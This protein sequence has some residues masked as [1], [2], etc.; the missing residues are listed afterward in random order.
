MG[1]HINAYP[2]S[3]RNRYTLVQFDGDLIIKLY[4]KHSTLL[5][6][7]GNSS[8]EAWNYFASITLCLYECCITMSKCGIHDLENSWLVSKLNLKVLFTMWLCHF[9]DDNHDFDYMINNCFVQMTRWLYGLH[10]SILYKLKKTL[11]GWKH[12]TMVKNYCHKYYFLKLCVFEL[13]PS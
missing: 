8:W 3:E 5:I 2:G 10:L 1:S 6:G 4:F 12:I 11:G 7:S 13:P 9:Y